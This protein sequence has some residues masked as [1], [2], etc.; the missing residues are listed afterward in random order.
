MLLLVLK[1]LLNMTRSVPY[2]N[3]IYCYSI[4]RLGNFDLLPFVNQG[5]VPQHKVLISSS[6]LSLLEQLLRRHLRE[7]RYTIL[8]E[9]RAT[10]ILATAWWLIIELL[11]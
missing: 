6:P 11:P 9:K 8:R 2:I 3:Q 4:D 1:D 5:S 10:S 7:F